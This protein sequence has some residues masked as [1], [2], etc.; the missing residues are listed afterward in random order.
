MPA[1][2]NEVSIP[3]SPGQVENIL[4]DSLFEVIQFAT[5]RI[6]FGLR[7]AATGLLLDVYS[8]LDQVAEQYRPNVGAGTPVYPDDYAL[9]DVAMAGEKLKVRARNTTGAPIVLQ[10][11]V[12]I[13]P[14]A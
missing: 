6:E 3:A 2:K 14:A 8:G 9:T 12:R 13:L 7:A 11:D 5:A 10:F 1:I 4:T